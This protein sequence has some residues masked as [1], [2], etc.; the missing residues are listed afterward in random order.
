MQ[1]FEVSIDSENPSAPIDSGELFFSQIRLFLAFKKCAGQDIA[2]EEFVLDTLEVMHS[3]AIAGL[4][5]SRF[6]RRNMATA[7]CV[8]L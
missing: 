2:S 6:I 4:R 8:N 7:G 5:Q 1:N 3:E